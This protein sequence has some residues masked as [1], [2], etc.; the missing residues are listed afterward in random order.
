LNPLVRSID[1][2]VSSGAAVLVQDVA[3]YDSQGLLHA[4]IDTLTG[5]FNSGHLDP[6]GYK[7]E[8]GNYTDVETQKQVF[9]LYTA[10]SGPGGS[11]YYD[12]LTGVS[13]ARDAA[14]SANE[15]ADNLNSIEPALHSAFVMGAGFVPGPVGALGSGLVDG[16]ITYFETG[17]VKTALVR[18]GT[19]AAVGLA[20]GKAGKVMGGPLS[21]F[22]AGRLSGGAAAAVAG[23]E[24]KAIA[25]P[26][27]NAIGKTN[28]FVAGTLVQMA[29]GT[30][31]PIEQVKVGEYV[32]SRNPQTGATEAKAV[33][34]TFQ[35]LAPQVLT[36]SLTDPR[37]GTAE[38][39]TCTPGHPFY[40]DGKGFVLAGQLGIG[41]S[42]VTRAGPALQV[43][44]LT[45]QKDKAQELAAGSPGSSFGGYTVYNL[46]V[47][48]DHTFF[49]GTT[50]GGT[51][52]HNTCRWKKG[53]PINA[54]I[55]G[56]Y[57]SWDVVK[58]R[59][60]KNHTGSNTAP[61]DSLY[62]VYKE[63]HHIN[64]RG[65][66]DPHNEGDLAAVWPW[67]HDAIDRFRHYT[68]TQPPGQGP[69]F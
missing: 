31:K 52:V 68:G 39:I 62:G 12:P 43:T 64:G 47:E 18:G 40:V 49:V 27:L 10:L 23:A 63:L 42:I 36:L 35:H 13:M 14:D 41:T 53:D 24:S 45:W 54:L 21:R 16:E 11:G 26:V 7:G 65:G 33:T 5:G 1:P 67:L 48:D 8:L 22:I 9:G 17:N 60:W 57:P 51:W 28:C 58:R 55:K 29:D 15:Y 2:N 59:F 20:F 69:G 25:S 19:T 66:S 30:T 4:D 38:R 34:E 61:Y 56:M 44:G 6:I 50:G 32:K 3:V 37:T 46:T